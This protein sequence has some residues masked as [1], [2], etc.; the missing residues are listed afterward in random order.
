MGKLF[1]PQ[2]ILSGFQTTNSLN[3]NFEAIEEALDACLSRTGETPNQMEADI[4][5]SGNDILNVRNVTVEPDLKEP[6]YI[7]G[8][9]TLERNDLYRVLKVTDEAVI[10]F[11][12]SE[13]FNP[14]W[15]CHIQKATG[16]S[17]VTFTS[18]DT[19]EAVMDSREILEQW[20]FITVFRASTS[21]WAV[22]GNLA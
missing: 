9:Y 2:D 10:T 14:G 16:T 22:T 15:Y 13:Q 21:V 5:F 8:D 20:G 11:P 18:T 7:S 3:T 19:I 17:P 4:D 6:K 12:D 1:T